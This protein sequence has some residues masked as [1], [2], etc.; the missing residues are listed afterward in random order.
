MMDELESNTRPE[1]DSGATEL[2]DR[3]ASPAPSFPVRAC[4]TPTV[5]QSEDSVRQRHKARVEHLKAAYG[6]MLDVPH[7]L[8][9]RLHELNRLDWTVYT[10]ERDGKKVETIV[11][12]FIDIPADNATSTAS[13][14]GHDGLVYVPHVRNQGAT[15]PVVV[16]ENSSFK[17]QVEQ[18][19]GPE[20][21]IP[22]SDYVIRHTPD[23]EA[24]AER[25]NPDGTATPIDFATDPVYA[26]PW[27]GG[28]CELCGNGAHAGECYADTLDD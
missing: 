23:P 4:P 12:A 14:I 11:P 8:V 26:D 21:G 18:T 22:S 15:P 3:P 25:V 16:P 17:P 20:R 28:R 13:Y 9:M 24:F 1:P 10:A 7:A 6:S 27:E 5:R 2:P 19:T